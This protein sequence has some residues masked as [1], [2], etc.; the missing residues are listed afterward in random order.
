V[1]KT[2]GWHAPR[3]YDASVGRSVIII[4]LLALC[5][6]GSAE[7]DQSIVDDDWRMPKSFPTSAE[8]PFAPLPTELKLYEPARAIGERLFIDKNLSGDRLVACI[9]CHPFDKGGADG[10]KF[11]SIPGREKGAQINV[12]TIFN[13]E[14]NSLFNWDGKFQSLNHQLGAPMQSHH[15]MRV[16]WQEMT[17][18]VKEDAAYVKSFKAAYDDGVTLDNIR[19]AIVTYERSLFTPNAPFDRWLRG[20]EG[21]KFGEPQRE[22]F[23]LFKDLGCATCHQGINLGGNMYAELGVMGDYFEDRKVPDSDRKMPISKKDRGRC[24]HTNQSEHCFQFRVP[25]LRNVGLT[26]PYLHDGTQENL[27]EAIKTMALYQL[28]R[29]LDPPEIVSLEAFLLSLTGTQPTPPPGH[30]K[31]AP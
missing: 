27:Y 24:E 26:Y 17:N 20:E 19:N 2:N 22:G 23:K 9:D 14:F 30:E 21:S 29:E 4:A 18:R 11:P 16:N 5:A 13:L 10:M 28:G 12:G 8:N 25:S 31:K 6:C 1:K 3:N 7:R 15:V